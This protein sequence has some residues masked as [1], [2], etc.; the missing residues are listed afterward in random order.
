MNSSRGNSANNGDASVILHFE[1]QQYGAWHSRKT[2][3]FPLIG[4][5]ENWV[6]CTPVARAGWRYSPTMAAAP[7]SLNMTFGLT[8]RAE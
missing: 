8:A 5:P 7:L 2:A 6:S 1:R 3:T 4:S